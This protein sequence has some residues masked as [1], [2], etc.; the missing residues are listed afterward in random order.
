[1]RRG[2]QQNFKP[3]RAVAGQGH[4]GHP[5]RPR[6]ESGPGRAGRPPGRQNSGFTAHLPGPVR[7]GGHPDGPVRHG[8]PGGDREGAGQAPQA[9]AG[10]PVAGQPD[11]PGRCAGCGGLPNRRVALD[12]GHHPER[13]GNPGQLGGG[14]PLLRR[15]G[16]G[17]AVRHSGGGDPV[18]FRPG[19]RPGDPGGDLAGVE[20][21]VL[22]EP[23]L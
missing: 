10:V 12:P 1:M 6:P 21:P 2:T 3:R 22:G 15:D 20:P 13:W 9:L 5:I 11:H 14:D 17:G 19:G 7:M 18:P 4:G 16:P 8:R 23:L